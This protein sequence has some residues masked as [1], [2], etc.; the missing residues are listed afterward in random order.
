MI[1][2]G[3]KARGKPRNRILTLENKPLVIKGEVGRDT[4]ETGDGD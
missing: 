4:G 2:G 1:L 3:E